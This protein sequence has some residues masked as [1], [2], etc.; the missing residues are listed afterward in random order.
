MQTILFLEGERP[1]DK[2][3]RIKQC[4]LKHVFR[5]FCMAFLLK[6]H[7]S[8]SVQEEHKQNKEDDSGACEMSRYRSSHAMRA[9]YM[10]GDCLLLSSV[11]PTPNKQNKSRS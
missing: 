6:K 8:G 10:D 1:K 7:M 3:A 2:Q 9:C 4:A 11:L 5:Y